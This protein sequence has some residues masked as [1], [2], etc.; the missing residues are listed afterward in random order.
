MLALKKY[1]NISKNMTNKLVL[2][3]YQIF[4]NN[5]WTQEKQCQSDKCICTIHPEE[6]EKQQL[7]PL[8]SKT[9]LF[10]KGNYSGEIT[11]SR[12]TVGQKVLRSSIVCSGTHCS[13]A[14]WTGPWSAMWESPDLIEG[15]QDLRTLENSFQRSPLLGPWRGLIDTRLS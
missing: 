5:D 6:I 7:L 13:R 2:K 9:E 1:W 15:K 8:P 10:F 3:K 4:N 11:L 12:R 14:R